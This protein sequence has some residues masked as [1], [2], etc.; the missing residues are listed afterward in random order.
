MTSSSYTGLYTH[1]YPSANLS[2]T[3]YEQGVKV[4]TGFRYG[5]VAR[6]LNAREMKWEGAE[7]NCIM[8]NSVISAL[9]Q[10]DQ[11]K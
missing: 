3:E 5:P 10:D 11:F 6:L 8:E 1:K 9:H 7:E 4:M 2:L